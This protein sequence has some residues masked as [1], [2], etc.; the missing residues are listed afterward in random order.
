M[1]AHFEQEEQLIKMA[2]ETL[3][4]ESVARILTEHA[5]L[6]A[7]TCGPCLL[8]PVERLRRFANLVVAHVRYEERVIF[9]Q[10]Q[11][12]PI[13]TSVDAFDPINLER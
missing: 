2:P 9:P 5:E 11:S 1:A 8:G 6:R 12:H 7:L 10:L 13:I 4:P 3:S